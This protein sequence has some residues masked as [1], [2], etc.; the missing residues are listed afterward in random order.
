LL[1]AIT[2][3]YGEKDSG[4]NLKMNLSS[5]IKVAVLRGGASNGY[6]DS[7]KTG[8]YVLST[9][10]EMEDVYEPLDIFISKEGEWHREGLVQ[11]P[12]Q[13]LAYIDVVWNALHG[14]YGEDGQ[15]GRV[16]ESL[17]ISFT[18]SGV[19][20]SALAMNKDM[21]KRLYNRYA[22]LTPAHELITKEDFNDERLIAIFKT[23]LSPM[24]V[25]PAN[26]S[27]SL[28]VSMAYTFNGLKKIVKETLNHSPRVIVEESIKGEEV[29]C[30][31]IEEARGE[32]IYALIPSNKSK[33]KLK[34]EENKK[35]EEM[36]KL[37]HEILGLRHYSS[38]NFVISPKRNIYILATNSLP[39]L[40]EDSSALSSLLSTG[41]R[42]RDFVD[43]ILKLAM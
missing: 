2:G 10:R 14:S 4:Y 18:G 35:I 25:K 6:F 34:A 20:P 19:V 27:G 26:T 24:I 31:V 12:H 38:S 21:S 32:R 39:P 36:A 33:L 17:Q 15:I 41:W 3:S 43:H 23:Y 22:L 13:A 11:E 30:L 5:K 1:S 16:L 29:S 37:A 28:G 42:P 9:L 40:H 8:K 7:L